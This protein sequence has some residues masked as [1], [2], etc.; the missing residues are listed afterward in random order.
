M[1]NIK[2]EHIEELETIAMEGA[3][4]IREFLTYRGSNKDY[5]QRAKYGAQALSGWNARQGQR[6][7]PRRAHARRPAHAA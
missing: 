2:D 7:E 4:A 5:L 6:G 3:R 1:K